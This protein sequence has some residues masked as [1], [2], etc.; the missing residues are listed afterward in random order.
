MPLERFLERLLTNPV[1]LAVWAV[2]VVAALAG[3]AHV[4]D[5]LFW[6]SLVF[7]L[8]VG[9]LVAYPVNVALVHRGVKDGMQ[10]PAALVIVIT[11]SHYRWFAETVQ[12]TTGKQLQ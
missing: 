3:E 5:V 6:T 2:V 10:N 8:T 9:L 11:V 4:G 12:R 1:V 7:S